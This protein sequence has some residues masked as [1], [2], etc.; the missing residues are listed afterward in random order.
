MIVIDTNVISEVMR[1]QPS[2]AV[3]HW[4]NK[5]TTHQLYTT[6][7]TI[8]EILYGLRIMPEGKRRR[9]LEFNFET[10]ITNAF[11][12]RILDFDEA[13]G[14][15]Y[16]DLMA[17][18]KTMGLPMSLSDGQIASIAYAHN[19]SVATRNIDDFESCGLELINPFEPGST[20]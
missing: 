12:P 5:Q 11:G 6:S 19:Y 20:S 17:Y 18:R 4:L 14:R 3:L 8:A 2:S 13:A 15:K 9:K 1:M 7:V 16:A 10:F